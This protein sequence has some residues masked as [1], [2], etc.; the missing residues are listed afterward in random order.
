MKVGQTLTIVTSEYNA[1][2]KEIRAHRPISFESSNPN[3]CKVGKKNSHKYGVAVA[4]KANTY[5]S[6]T[7]TAKAAG[8]CT[9]WVFAQNGIYT[10][11]NVKVKP[12][13]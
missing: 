8:E 1:D 6:R 13:D 7:I 12:A 2:G 9:I 3:I 4:G 5:K 10:K 11:V